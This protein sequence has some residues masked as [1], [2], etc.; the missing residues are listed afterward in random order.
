M[1]LS[2][3]REYGGLRFIIVNVSCT[4]SCTELYMIIVIHSL[5]ISRI[6]DL[7][8]VLMFWGDLVTDGKSDGKSCQLS[9][10]SFLLSKY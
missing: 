9:H 3:I 4:R 7:I 2:L 10:R 6:G 1:T 5:S 8:A